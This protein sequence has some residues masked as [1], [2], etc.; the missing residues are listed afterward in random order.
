MCSKQE[1][2]TRGLNTKSKRAS[3]G[4]AQLVDLVLHDEGAE[5]V[6]IT[7]E[8]WRMIEGKASPIRF[9]KPASARALP[10]PTVGGDLSDLRQ[11][12]NV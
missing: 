3:A 9:V 6:E 8:G 5:V 12:I 1:P 2:Y 4:R 10:E 11:F 7:S